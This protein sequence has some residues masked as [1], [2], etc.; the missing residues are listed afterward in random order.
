VCYYCL[1]RRTELSKLKVSDI[2]LKTNT[3]FIHSENSKNK[4]SAHV[5]MPTELKKLL[6]KH[7]S[8]AKKTNYLFSANNY[9]P[10]STNFHPDKCSKKWRKMRLYLKLDENIK[11]Y[12]LKDTGITDL[13][14]AGVDLVSVR[15][16]ARH[17][18]IK[19]TN[20][21]IPQNLKT[22]NDKIINS[23]V[24]FKKKYKKVSN[25]WFLV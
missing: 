2:N 8:G 20:T 5:T 7:I 23:G 4:Q 9:A 14:I 24:K 1:I 16:Q 15:D 21:Y 18:S 22:A 19:Q 13:I 3:I 6:K 11:W 25:S 17:H 10:G 12:S